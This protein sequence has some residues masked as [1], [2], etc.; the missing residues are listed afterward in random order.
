VSN[1]LKIYCSLNE[2]KFKILNVNTIDNKQM[3]LRGLLMVRYCGFDCEYAEACDEVPSCMTYNPI[4]C[5]LQNKTVSKGM[6]CDSE[7]LFNGKK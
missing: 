5:K 7:E 1:I 4:H 2:R 3:L 6:V